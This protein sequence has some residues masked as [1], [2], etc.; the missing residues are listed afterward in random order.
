MLITGLA[1]SIRLDL[2]PKSS[3][4]MVF[5]FIECDGKESSLAAGFT[6]G[7]LALMNAGIEL[8]DMLVG[9]SMVKHEIF[10]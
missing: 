9:C 5:Y 3:I 6:C 2:Y 8:Y 1:P 10:L 4:D 7:S